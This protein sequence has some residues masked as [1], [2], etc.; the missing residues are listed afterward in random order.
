VANLYKDIT[1]IKCKRYF[2]SWLSSYAVRSVTWE[3]KRHRIAEIHIKPLH[4]ATTLKNTTLQLAQL[5]HIKPSV[6][7]VTSLAL[8]LKL[9]A[10]ASLE[11]SCAFFW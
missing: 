2:N 4:K 9:Q 8:R 5:Y 1:S 6:D 10:Y 3:E 7:R 11:M